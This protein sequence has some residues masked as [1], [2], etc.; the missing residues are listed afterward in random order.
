MGARAPVS[1]TL[2][3]S[4]T[5]APNPAG[6]RSELEGV[7]T[8]N[9]TATTVSTRASISRIFVLGAGALMAFLLGAALALAATGWFGDGGRSAPAFDSTNALHTHV[10][11][12]YSADTAAPALVVDDALHQHV[13]RENGAR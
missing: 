13:M 5:P 10:L 6:N 2:K 11:R 9:A 4:A 3:D 8:M 7:Q 1:F 12:E